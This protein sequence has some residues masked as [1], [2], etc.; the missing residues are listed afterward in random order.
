MN[1]SLVLVGLDQRVALH[2]RLVA[3]EAVAPQQRDR[4]LEDLVELTLRDVSGLPGE[5]R[6]D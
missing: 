3:G 2:L 4:L 6:P 5:A 1:G